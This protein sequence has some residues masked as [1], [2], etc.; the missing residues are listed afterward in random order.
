MHLPDIPRTLYSRRKWRQHGTTT[1]T[2]QVHCSD[3]RQRDRCGGRRHMVAV[4]A[5]GADSAGDKQL[6]P[7]QTKERRSPKPLS[8][9]SVEYVC[10]LLQL[11]MCTFWKDTW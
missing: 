11:C 7:R 9:L 4:L 10:Q 1:R 2:W 3:Y 5:S 6:E 8:R